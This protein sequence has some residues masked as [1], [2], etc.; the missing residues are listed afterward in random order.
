MTLNLFDLDLHRIAHLS[1][2]QNFEDVNLYNFL[3]IK[4]ISQNQVSF[5]FGTTLSIF[6]RN[7]IEIGSVV[8][9][10]YQ[11]KRANF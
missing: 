5:L 9:S 6:P 3:T 4:L 8:C 1:N 7:F 10:K 11:K 2:I